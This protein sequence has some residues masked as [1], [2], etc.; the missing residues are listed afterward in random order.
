MA[1]KPVLHRILVKPDAIEDKDPAFKS[2]RDTG[3]IIHRDER[4]REQAAVDSGTVLDIGETAFSAFMNEKPGASFPV[5]VGDTIV[6]ARYAGKTVKD[7]DDN[8]DYV[9]LNDEDVVA[10]VTTKQGA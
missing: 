1:I 6:Y 9:L 7:P 2:A 8:K 4:T 10:I 5:K 3:I